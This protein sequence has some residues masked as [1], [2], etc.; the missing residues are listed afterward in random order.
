MGGKSWAPWQGD[1]GSAPNYIR[2]C[3]AKPGQ[4]PPGE[5]VPPGTGGQGGC[6]EEGGYLTAGGDQEEGGPGL[7]VGPLQ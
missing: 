2:T 6:R 1:G 7:Q 5:A 3:G 4:L